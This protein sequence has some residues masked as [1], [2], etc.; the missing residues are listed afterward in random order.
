MYS[1]A[2]CLSKH[3]I[4]KLSLVL[5]TFEKCFFVLKAGHARYS[6]LHLHEVDGSEHFS[7]HYEDLC[8]PILVL[9]NILV[10][11][12]VRNPHIIFAR[13]PSAQAH[14][15]AARMDHGALCPS[16]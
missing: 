12:H 16:Y 1:I 6:L 14:S 10:Q 8:D 2:R 11:R 4:G 9:Y 5:H 13:V 7:G 15:Y 3:A